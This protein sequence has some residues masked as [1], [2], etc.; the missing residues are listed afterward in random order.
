MK[1]AEFERKVEELD[2]K[3][4]AVLAESRELQS[5]KDETASQASPP[6]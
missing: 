5:K 6:K 3:I 2:R 1:T 4:N